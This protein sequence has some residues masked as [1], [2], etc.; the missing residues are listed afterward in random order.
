MNKGFEYLSDWLRRLTN[1]VYD[2]NIVI[3]EVTNILVI[4]LE[5]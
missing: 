4:A 5:E 3:E 1:Y 2:N